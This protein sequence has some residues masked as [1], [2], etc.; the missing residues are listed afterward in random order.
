MSD[1]VESDF[2]EPFSV[3]NLDYELESDLHG[4]VKAGATRRIALK[5]VSMDLGT[6]PGKV[7]TVKLDVSYDDGSTWQKVTL[8]KG[9][10]G[11]WAGSF[12]TARKP[13]GF[14]SVRAS[15]AT[16]RGFSVKN[17]IIRAY[18]LR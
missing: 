1:T 3:L 11:S 16:D 12:K 15:A 7:T 17:E 10:G 18:G 8:S 6:V 4:D 5:P 14:V 13:G 2:F 9:S